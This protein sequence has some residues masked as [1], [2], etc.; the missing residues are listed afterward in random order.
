LAVSVSERKKKKMTKTIVENMLHFIAFIII[1]FALFNS[2]IVNSCPI[3]VA[4][5]LAGVFIIKNGSPVTD[6]DDEMA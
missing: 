2:K 4:I 1:T 5:A 3:L 6:L